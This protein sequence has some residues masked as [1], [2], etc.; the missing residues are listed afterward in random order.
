MGAGAAAG[1][2]GAG[3]GLGRCATLVCHGIVLPCHGVST[4]MHSRICVPEELAFPWKARLW[5]EEW[6]VPSQ[7]LRSLRKYSP[8]G[9]VLFQDLD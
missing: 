9:S 5:G 7:L 4:T 8:I 1:R 6:G 2:G 3:E